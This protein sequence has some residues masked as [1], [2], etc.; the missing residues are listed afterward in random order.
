MKTREL[1]ENSLNMAW[2]VLVTL[3]KFPTVTIQQLISQTENPTLGEKLMEMNY[4]KA[5]RE[6]KL[7]G[8]WFINVALCME[9]FNVKFM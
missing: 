5:E 4:F 6:R 7:N 8:L 9:A 1:K 3:S 2:S